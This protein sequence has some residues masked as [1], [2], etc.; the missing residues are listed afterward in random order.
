VLYAGDVL[1]SVDGED[2]GAD[3]KVR[4]GD[5]LRVGFDHLV[6]RHQVGD[7]IELEVLREGERESVAFELDRSRPEIVPRGRP[8]AADYFVYGGL[9]FQR[10]SFDYLDALHEADRDDTALALPHAALALRDQYWRGDYVVVSSVLGHA[11]NQ[12]YE[13]AAGC[14]VNWVN[15]QVVDDLEHLIVRITHAPGPTVELRMADGRLLV[16]DR[17][18]VRDATMEILRGYGLA[19]DRSESLRVVAQG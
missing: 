12:G 9:V 18:E 3:G 11:V 17:A 4:L 5:G 15:G 19:W 8:W 1:L 16:L 10:L 13:W 6:Q 7:E 2:I 14:L